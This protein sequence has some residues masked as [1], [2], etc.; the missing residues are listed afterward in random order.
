M[1]TSYLLP[2]EAPSS[3]GY[4]YPQLRAIG[5]CLV[6]GAKMKADLNK[7]PVRLNHEAFLGEAV[8][9]SSEFTY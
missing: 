3:S 7:D 4:L 9:V 5:Q 1:F 8:A 2:E 6:N